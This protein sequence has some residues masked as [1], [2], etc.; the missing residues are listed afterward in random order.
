MSIPDGFIE[1]VSPDKA[2]LWYSGHTR[3][4][5]KRRYGGRGNRHAQDAWRDATGKRMPFAGPGGE[6]WVVCHVYP[7]AA[8]CPYHF[9]HT[10]GLVLIHPSYA[11]Q[12][13]QDDKTVAWLQEQAFLRFQYD[14]TGKFSGKPATAGC[15]HLLCHAKVSHYAGSQAP[16]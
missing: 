2:R 7:W 9:S 1:W 13:D 10:A 15:G 3:E 8:K 16:P 12:A 11:W 4:S 6:T 14:P 5:D